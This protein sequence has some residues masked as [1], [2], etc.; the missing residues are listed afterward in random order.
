[1]STT[2]AGS[3]E[4][5]VA[6]PDRVG[7]LGGGRMGA[8]IAH[9]LLLA[10]SH[11]TVVERDASASAAARA[12]IERAV[13]ASATRGQLTGT[14]QDVIARL[15]TVHDRD[16]LVGSQLVIEAVPEILDLKT[17]ALAD[18]EQRLEPDAVLASN[19]SSMSIKLIAGFLVRPDRFIGMHFFNPVPASKLVEIV[20]GPET[21]AELRELV[22]GWVRTLGKTAVVVND[23]PGFASSRLGLALGL[24]AVRM[25]EEGVASAADID[26]AMS[27]GYGHPMGPLRLTDLVGL[28][29]RLDIA[30]YLQERLGDR[31]APPQLLIDKVANGELGRK[32]GRGFYNW[33][34]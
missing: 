19:T 14:A 32:S 9:A 27:L 21:S 31:F 3:D 12:R 13:E 1:V 29:V 34:D 17:E 23:A 16:S 18:V 8:G 6:L 11:V 7:V 26:A 28:D 2:N 10:G 4:P 22:P 24:E 20:V 25:L 33:S 5:K 30:R 15:T